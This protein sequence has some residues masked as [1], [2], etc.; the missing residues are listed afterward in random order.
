PAD[1]SFTAS[2]AAPPGEAGGGDVAAQTFHA[3]LTGGLL[4]AGLSRGQ[5]GQL[6][7]AG[8]G[9]SGHLSG[10][11]LLFPNGP[12]GPGG[13]LSWVGPSFAWTAHEIVLGL[14]NPGDQNSQEGSTVSLAVVAHSSPVTFAA[15]NLPKGLGIDPD[16]GLISGTID[17]TAGAGSPYTATVTA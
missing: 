14:D 13:T 3:A 7:S 17:A 9:R 10:P 16:T 12:Q 8:G 4:G 11:L 2:A 1:G 15:V 6:L 5:A